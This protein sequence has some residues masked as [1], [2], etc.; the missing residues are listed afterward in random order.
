MIV[1][2]HKNCRFHNVKNSSD[3]DNCNNKRHR[4]SLCQNSVTFISANAIFIN[5]CGSIGSL[6]CTLFCSQTF[7]TKL[8]NTLDDL[9]INDI[10]FNR[11]FVTSLT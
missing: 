10:Q 9:Q 2:D 8:I 6:F 1:E 4:L 11:G 3:Y 5:Y 7:M